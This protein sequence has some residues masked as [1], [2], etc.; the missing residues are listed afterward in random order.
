MWFNKTFEKVVITEPVQV[1]FSCWLLGIGSPLSEVILICHSIRPGSSEGAFFDYRY[2]F[3]LPYSPKSPLHI[4]LLKKQP[5]S[6]IF[7]F[8]INTYILRPTVSFGECYG[9]EY[10]RQR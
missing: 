7:L 8:Y 2:G 9:L 4:S 6:P 10:C 5:G 3:N 1:R